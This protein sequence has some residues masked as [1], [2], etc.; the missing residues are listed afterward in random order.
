MS[1]HRLERLQ[2]STGKLVKCPQDLYPVCAVVTSSVA[3]L[4]LPGKSAGLLESSE[5]PVPREK[6]EVQAYVTL[7]KS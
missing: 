2:I 6:P 3:V 5:L 7:S 1:N 4:T